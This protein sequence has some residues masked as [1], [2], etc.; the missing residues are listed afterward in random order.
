[1]KRI[2][3]GIQDYDPLVQKTIHRIQSKELVESCH[4]EALKAGYKSISH[5]LVFGL[6][7]QTMTGFQDTINQTL[8]LQPHRISLYSYAHVPWV[9]GTGQRGYDEADLPKPE[10]KR[11]LYEY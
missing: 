7:K 9:K 4:Q 10:E 8:K 3:F 2:S 11:A 1:F 6:P 5:D